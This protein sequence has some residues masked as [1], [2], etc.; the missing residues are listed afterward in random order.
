MEY[1]VT[2][3]L[4]DYSIGP[5][6]LA[7][8]VLEVRCVDRCTI[9][10]HTVR[11]AEVEQPVPLVCELQRGVLARH[12]GVVKAEIHVRTPSQRQPCGHE[13]VLAA[14]TA[15]GDLDEG[16][17]YSGQKGGFGSFV[18]SSLDLAR[19]AL[20]HSR[21]FHLRVAGRSACQFLYLSATLGLRVRK[22][23]GDLRWSTA[24]RSF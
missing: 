6:E 18:A 14:R 24:S 3:F 23:R 22:Q 15:A 17:P 11:A 4:T 7:I 9:H 10:K 8:A 12:R 13:L 20:A 21:P 19:S 1:G 2:L 5:A 16:H